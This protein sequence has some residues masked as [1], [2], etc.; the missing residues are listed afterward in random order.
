MAHPPRPCSA[1][2][3][4]ATASINFLRSPAAV[5]DDDLT[6]HCDDYYQLSSTPAADM[7]FLTRG[8]EA[9]SP[10]MYLITTTIKGRIT[11]Q[12]ILGD[13]S[14]LQPAAATAPC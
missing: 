11:T 4:A 3:E 14:D 10:A 1:V 5:H 9:S 7:C 2:T 8:G 6:V 13:E 12:V